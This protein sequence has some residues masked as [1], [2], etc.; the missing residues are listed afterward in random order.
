[1]YM[2]MYQKMMR[3]CRP[4]LSDEKLRLK[5]AFTVSYKKA[6]TVNI[7]RVKERDEGLKQLKLCRI[8]QF[9]EITVST[10]EVLNFFLLMKS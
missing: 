9:K 7:I 10:C 1:M 2:L 5:L 4:E 6:N 3:F 8:M